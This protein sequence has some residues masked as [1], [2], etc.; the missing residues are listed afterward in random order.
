MAAP[1]REDF[2]SSVS[3]R[4]VVAENIVTKGEVWISEFVWR[5]RLVILHLKVAM[6]WFR[7][8]N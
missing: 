2:E 5:Q 7:E 6:D 4:L 8:L 1:I 3:P